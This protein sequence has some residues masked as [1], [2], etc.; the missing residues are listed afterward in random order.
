MTGI[1]MLFPGQGSQYKGMFAN[2]RDRYPAV[3]RTFEEASDALGFDLFALCADGSEAELAEPQNAQP[4][5]LAA[6]VAAY[7][8]WTGETGEVPAALAGHSLGEY[9]ALAC[10][11]SMPFRDALAIVRL[12]GWLMREGAAGGRRG[13][14]LAVSGLTAEETETIV[15]GLPAYGDELAVACYNA[16]RQQVISGTEAALAEAER[17]LAAR[18][19]RTVPLKVGAAFHGPLM[20]V[21]ARKLEEALRERADRIAAPR[22][23]VVS[24]VTALPY[25]DTA[26]AVIRGLV[27]QMTEPVRW[28]STMAY[29]RREG[30]GLA[31]DCG[32]RATLKNLLLQDDSAA[33][34][35]AFDAPDDH[36]KLFAPEWG[37]GRRARP[38]NRLL[39]ACLAAAAATR[40]RSEDTRAYAAAVVK[41]Y[42]E[43]E[44]LLHRAE[45]RGTD[46]ADEDAREALRLLDAIMAAKGA[47]DEERAARTNAIRFEIQ[48]KEGAS[49]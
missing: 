4:A 39:E 23:P 26:E 7:R 35:Y 25:G 40:N 19:A 9:T 12:R 30:V 6:G 5:L 44:A 21:A 8:A 34:A 32:P 28:K 47:G 18:G 2:H 22:V 13:G 17:E 37:A 10:A 16:L 41:P 29:L 31:I 45:S 27:R 20:A 24:N 11:G 38:N 48:G 14:M 33:V 46:A 43:I 3:R 1:A 49:C 36:G 15:S 42:R